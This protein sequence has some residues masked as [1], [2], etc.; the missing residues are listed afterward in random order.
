MASPNMHMR[1]SIMFRILHAYYH[2]TA[3]KYGFP[4]NY[5]LNKTILWKILKKIFRLFVG[6][7]VR[8]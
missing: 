5:G 4:D 6:G 2:R 3:E 8:L 7:E 1:D